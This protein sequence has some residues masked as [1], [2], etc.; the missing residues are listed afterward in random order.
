MH[1]DLNQSKRDRV[2][3]AFRNGSIEILVATDVAARGLDVSG[4]T[5][6]FNFDILRILTAMC[7]VL[8]V[9]G[10]PARAVKPLPL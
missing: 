3:R 7:I 1:G 2:M 10:E 9:P 8:A 5:H 4:V 6:V